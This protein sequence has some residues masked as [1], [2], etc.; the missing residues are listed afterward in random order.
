MRGEGAKV[1]NEIIKSTRGDSISTSQD[2][3]DKN[4]SIGHKVA[5]SKEY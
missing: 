3:R 1:I 5:I 4:N 2:S